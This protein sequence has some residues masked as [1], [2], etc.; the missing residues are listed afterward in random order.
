VFKLLGI[1]VAIYVVFAAF[2]GRV[3]A[4]RAWLRRPSMVERS[5]EPR[6]FWTVIAIY[7][8]LAVALIT[9]F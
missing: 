3:Y 9:V 7:G 8:A 5:A 6:W 1:A 4:E 2:D